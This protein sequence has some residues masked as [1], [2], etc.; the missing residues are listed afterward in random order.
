[1]GNSLTKSSHSVHSL[2]YH[3]IQCVHEQKKIFEDNKIVDLLKTQVYNISKNFEVEVLEIEPAKDYFHMV[4]KAKPTLDITKYLNTIKCITSREIQRNFPKTA[5]G[6]LWTSSYF[7]STSG[8][9][10]LETLNNYIS[11]QRKTK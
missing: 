4:F 3:L 5:K 7:L 6:N 2:S 9:V 8:Q 1:M 10:T 11:M